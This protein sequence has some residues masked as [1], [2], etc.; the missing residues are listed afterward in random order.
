M[1]AFFLA[2]NHSI[3]CFIVAGIRETNI[4]TS[5]NSKFTRESRRFRA[6]SAHHFHLL[7]DQDFHSYLEKTTTTKQNRETLLTILR[8]YATELYQVGRRV[9]KKEIKVFLKGKLSRGAVA[10]QLY[11]F[12]GFGTSYTQFEKM[13][14]EMH[15]NGAC[16]RN[17]L[18]DGGKAMKRTNVRGETGLVKL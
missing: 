2:R 1:K 10:M 15:K 7:L 8:L 3:N 6:T 14:S 5:R 11:W 9:E 17:H 18:H 4:H 16:G 12:L 13:N